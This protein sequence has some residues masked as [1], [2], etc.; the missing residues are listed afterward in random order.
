MNHNNLN[1]SEMLQ[2]GRVSIID[3]SDTDSPLVNNLVIAQ[4]LRGVQNR[5]NECYKESIMTCPHNVPF[6][7]T[8]YISGLKRTPILKPLFNKD[9]IIYVLLFH[10]IA[11]IKGIGHY[12]IPLNR[13][14]EKM[15]L[16][17]ITR[18]NIP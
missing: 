9:S 4:L 3:L 6:T 15:E 1:Y 14:K 11:N 5:Q 10:Y 16:P 17:D 18:L 12:P 13:F 8:I 2:P 7:L